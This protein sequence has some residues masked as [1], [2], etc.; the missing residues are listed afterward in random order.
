MIL[1]AVGLKSTHLR[2]RVFSS[3]VCHVYI[4]TAGWGCQ[5]GHRLRSSFRQK[6]LMTRAGRDRA[7]KEGLP[8]G[9]PA[10]LTDA[11]VGGR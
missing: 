2:F 3:V 1:E 8:G 10:D 6:V 7:P 11:S 4:G 9:G 5:G